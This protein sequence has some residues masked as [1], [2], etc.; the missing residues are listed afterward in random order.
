MMKRE[1]R[2]ESEKASIMLPVRLFCRSLVK[3]NRW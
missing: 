3:G 2:E 1:Q